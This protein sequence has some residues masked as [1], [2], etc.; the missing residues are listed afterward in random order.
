M[1]TIVDIMFACCIL[2]N[3][4]LDD[5]CDASLELPFDLD[6]VVPFEDLVFVAVEIENSN[7]YYSLSGDLIEHNWA[8]EGVNIY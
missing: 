5:E 6:Q 1:D 7:I 3:M 8:L 2:Y 4:S